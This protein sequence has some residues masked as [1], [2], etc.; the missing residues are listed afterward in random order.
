[1]TLLNFVGALVCFVEYNFSIVSF[2]NNVFVY[3]R[4]GCYRCIRHL[5]GEK[6]KVQHAQA[7]NFCWT[8]I[9]NSERSHVQYIPYWLL[10]I[11]NG[12]WSEGFFVKEENVEK[13]RIIIIRPMGTKNKL[14]NLVMPAWGIT[15]MLQQWEVLT[16][17]TT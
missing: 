8:T 6:W 11:W 14:N 17:I 7:G 3:R 1:M 12:I 5:K 13:L 10:R 15:A 16:I 2:F 4:C 9:S